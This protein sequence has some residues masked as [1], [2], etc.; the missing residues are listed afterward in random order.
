MALEPF[1]NIGRVEMG[2]A[3]A[4]MVSDFYWRRLADPVSGR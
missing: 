2:S 1:T 3:M 4:G